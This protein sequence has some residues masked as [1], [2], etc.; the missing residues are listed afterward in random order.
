MKKIS[1]LIFLFVIIGFTACSP[2]YLASGAMHASYNSANSYKVAIMPVHV[3]AAV[4]ATN[5]DLAD[6]AYNM[7]NGELIQVSNF[8]II[9]QATVKR[10]VATLVFGGS[11]ADTEIEKKAALAVGA[12]IAVR[13]NVTREKEGMPILVEVTLYDVDNNIQLYYGKGRAA[14]PLSVEAETEAA[15]EFAFMEMKKKLGLL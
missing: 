14:N 7:V 3:A 11:E 13:T 15:V 1:S 12:N 2:K 9:D 5:P 10:K 4:K 6:R 8:Q